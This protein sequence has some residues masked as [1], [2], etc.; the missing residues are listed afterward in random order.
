MSKRYLTAQQ[1]AKTLAISLST[2]YA[3]V[4]G[5]LIRSEQTGEGKRQRRYYAEDVE[6]ITGAA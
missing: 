3:Y 4:S 6:K 1:A 5:G 2:L